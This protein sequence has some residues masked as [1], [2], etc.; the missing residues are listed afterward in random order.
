M[1]NLKKA[2]LKEMIKETVKEVLS[3]NQQVLTESSLNRIIYW[4]QNHEIALITAFRGKKEN[5]LH[6]DLTKDDD[7]NIGDIYSKTEN[8][9][10]NR[11]LSASLLRMGYGIT[12]I[13]G[14]YIENFGLPNSRIVDEDSFLVVNKNNDNNFYNNIFK[15]SEYYNQDC[16]CYKSKDENVAYNVG[17]NGCDYPGYGN[18]VRNG[19]FVYGVKNEFMSRIRNKGFAFTDKEKLETFQTTHNDRKIERM[20]KKMEQALNEEIKTFDD[21]ETLTKQT[22]AHIG[23]TLINKLNVNQ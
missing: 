11:E 3:E 5:V 10:R 19:K 18:K 8:R 21:Y 20:N 23:D 1:M 2:E 7:K 17:T 6:D 12:K 16:F 14:V 22:I 15:L 4:I 9:A 13:S